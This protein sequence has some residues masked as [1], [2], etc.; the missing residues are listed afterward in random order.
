LAAYFGNP[1]SWSYFQNI[2][3]YIHYQLP[4]VLETNPYPGVVNGSLWSLPA[5]IFMYL[6]VP[7]VGQIVAQQRFRYGF[8]LAATIVVLAN[9]YVFQIAPQPP[10]RVIFYAT[11]MSAWL[12]LRGTPSSLY[13]FAI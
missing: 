8:L 1:D 4:G 13:R 10:P 3:L 6:I 2:A 12:A 5:E 11:D 7:A 9:V